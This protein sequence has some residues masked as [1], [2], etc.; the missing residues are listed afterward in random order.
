MDKSILKDLI[1]QG[2]STRKIAIKM[3]CSQTNVSYWMSKHGLKAICSQNKTE[4]FCPR[5]QENLKI[6]LFYQRRGKIGGSVYCKRCTNSQATERQKSFKLKCA[7][8]K[9]GKCS[10]CGYSKSLS[11]LEFHHIISEEKDFS[12]SKKRSLTFDNSIKKELDKCLL[13]CANCHR[14]EHD[15]L[16][17]ELG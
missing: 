1:E 6:S 14:E 17:S 15:R 7:E 4:K 9:G 10:N 12:I 3:N 11:A 13:L 5:C 16:Y 8:Y 2:L